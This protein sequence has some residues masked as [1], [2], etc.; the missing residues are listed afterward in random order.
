MILALRR[1]VIRLKFK[2]MVAR[3]DDAI[4]DARAKHQPVRHLE[5]AKADYVRQ[6][7]ERRA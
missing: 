6:C 2:K 3:F 4:A 1:Y 7:L 5:R